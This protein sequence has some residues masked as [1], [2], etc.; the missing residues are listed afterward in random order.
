MRSPTLSQL[1]RQVRLAAAVVVLSATVFAAG[2]AGAAPDDIGSTASADAV[3]GRGERT[4]SPTDGEVDV[5]SI[6]EYGAMKAPTIQRVEALA[7]RLGITSAPVRSFQFGLSQVRRGSTVVQR[8]SGTTG[9]WQYPLS[10]TAFP[11]YAVGPV[12]GDDV[13][14]TLEG[15]AVVMGQT[16]ADLRGAVAGDVVDLVS[17]I[18]VVTSFTVGLVAPDAV[19]GGAELVLS[20]TQ[21]ALL[22]PLPVTR[23]VL[24]GPFDRSTLMAAI[25]SA[26]LVNNRNARIVTSWGPPNPDGTLGLAATKALLGEFDYR[27]I[28]R[29]YVALDPA[30]V[31]A[32]I[33]SS[34][35]LYSGVAVR[36][37]CHRTVKPHLQAALSEVAS[38][39][40]AWAI[41]LRNT[42]TYGGCFNPR[43]ARS[44]SVAGSISRH[45]WGMAFDANTVTNAQGKEPP[46]MDC[47][48]VRIFRKHGFAWGGN[49]LLADG[50]H[51]EF[52]GERRD[53]WP[54]PSEYCPNLVA[55]ASASVQAM[56]PEARDTMFGVTDGAGH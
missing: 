40:I 22:G 15:G 49:F 48:V 32:N 14:A 5:V 18:G 53:Q 35:E 41:D 20:A 17:A 38:A 36:A 45:T 50:M 12:F 25:D 47:R 13:A 42:N 43:Y 16:A 31:T 21:A 27:I 10:L 6:S 9:R 3:A 11:Q 44:S 19:V 8:A 4:G 34:R 56:W 39:G 7:D 46:G 54:Y 23:V 26:G 29:Q 28:D 51:F 37:R 30:W 24:H 33:P 52:V 55:E 1:C 2:R